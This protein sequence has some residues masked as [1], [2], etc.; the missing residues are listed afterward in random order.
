MIQLILS[1]LVGLVLA[2][3]L[4]FFARR[5]KPSAEGSAQQFREARQTLDSLQF[6]LL[7]N[8]LVERIFAREDLEYVLS[9][10]PPRRSISFPDGSQERC[11]GLGA[12]SARCGFGADAF[13]SRSCAPACAA[14]L[15]DGNSPGAEFRRSPDGVPPASDHIVSA[16]TVCC[17]RNGTNCCRGGWPEFVRSQRTLSRSLT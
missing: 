15:L 9:A 11:L 16:R 8:D 13:S 1:L 14:E 2:V 17:S 12:P 6:G 10:A 3:S 7:P 4:Y 5:A